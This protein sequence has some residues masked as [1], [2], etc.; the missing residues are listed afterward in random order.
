[1]PMADS[2]S[3]SDSHS[4]SDSYSNSGLDADSDS[5]SDSDLHSD[6]VSDSESDFDSYHDSDA[7][8]D[9]D[10]ESDSHSDPDAKAQRAMLD[11]TQQLNQADAERFGHESELEARIHAFELAYKINGPSLLATNLTL[12]SDFAELISAIDNYTESLNNLRLEEIVEAGLAQASSVVDT[13]KANAETL[14]V[15]WSAEVTT[16]DDEATSAEAAAADLA[17]TA[18]ASADA[19]SLASALASEAVAAAANADNELASA[20]LLGL[21][22]VAPTST[23]ASPPGL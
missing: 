3:H 5:E 21:C 9:S 23:K 15:N 20:A 17:V 12:A 6:S 7:D 18:A 2:G 1:M 22:G 4:E 19:V 16:R 11:F 13:Y 10:P 14:S 8:Y